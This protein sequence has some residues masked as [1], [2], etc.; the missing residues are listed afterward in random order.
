MRMLPPIIQRE[1]CSY[2]ATPTAYLLMMTFLVLCGVCTFYPGGFFERNQADLAPFFAYHPWIYL[3]LMPALAMRQW[4]EERKSGTIEILMTLPLTR[5]EVVVGKYLA[6]WLI[7][8]LMLL[9]TVPIVLTVNYLGEPDN[10]AI[11][12]GY[13]GSWLLAGVYLAISGCM[14]ALSR[15]QVVAYL[16]AAMVGLLFIASGSA[17]VLDLLKQ[18]APMAWLDVSASMSFL[19]RFGSISQ[20]VI[21]PRDLIYFFGQIVAWLAATALVVDLKKAS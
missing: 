11:L 3:L 19:A 14:S 4:A 21:A 9:L 6:A 1:F 20:G 5:F 12:C 10:G 7:A 16:M 15:S 8:A 2:F 13:L 17:P 18:W